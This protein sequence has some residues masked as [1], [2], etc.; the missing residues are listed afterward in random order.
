MRK[1]LYFIE[2]VISERKFFGDYYSAGPI[3]GM[4]FTMNSGKGKEVKRS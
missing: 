2:I 1:L 3:S 4:G